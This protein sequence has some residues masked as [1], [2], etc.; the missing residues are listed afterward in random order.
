MRFHLEPYLRILVGPVNS[1][2]AEAIVAA[3]KRRI[4]SSHF[5]AVI[6]WL[7]KFLITSPVDKLEGDVIDTLAK[8]EAHSHTR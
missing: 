1:Q 4:Y 8:Y 5:L 6:I 7:S 2:A 3:P